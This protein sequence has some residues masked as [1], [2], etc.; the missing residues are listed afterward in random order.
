MKNFATTLF[1]A[2]LLIL[3]PGL[4]SASGG[5]YPLDHAPDRSSDLPALQNGAKLFVNYCLNCHSAN[6]MRYN[7][8]KD[9]GLTD[10]QIKANLLFSA[11]KVG[12][13]M[14]VA[15]TPKDGK[16]WF[17]AAPPDLSVIARAKASESGS[18]ADYIYTYLRTYYRDAAR[19]TGW[20]NLA[21]PNSA[22]PHILWER[23]GARELNTVLIHEHEAEGKGKVW[24]KVETTYD[25][26]GV[27]TVKKTVMEDYH[28]HGGF[29]AKFSVKD[30]AAVAAYDKDV[31]DLTGYINY[32][33]D[34][35]ATLRQ[36]L[37]VWVLMFL[38]IFFVFA[39]WL[40]RV[41]WRD[42]K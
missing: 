33:S 24:E 15:M 39:W 8:L 27:A 30:A 32:M 26:K 23:Q 6:L 35:S 7:R 12:E 42:V 14:H 38:A 22:M 18:G 29:E 28:G 9:L 40:N 16:E 10:D 36:R 11:D 37:G 2:A 1:A 20:N 3:A 25:V 41:F 17:G 5:G 31:A 34:P 21:Y 13:T 19:P 4:S